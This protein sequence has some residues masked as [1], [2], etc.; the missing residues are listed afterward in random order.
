MTK[1]QWQA[2]C[3][4]GLSFKEYFPIA[5]AHIGWKYT[6]NNLNVIVKSLNK[7]D[8]FDVAMDTFHDHFGY[9]NVIEDDV[10]FN[11]LFE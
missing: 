1:N 10:L 9:L 7:E 3:K 8:A 2:Y 6:Y 4:G 5:M 11:P